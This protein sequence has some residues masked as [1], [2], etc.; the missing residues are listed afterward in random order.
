MVGLEGRVDAILF[1]A[2]I[3]ENAS[4]IRELCM[5]N[6]SS[7]GIELDGDK[8]NAPNRDVREISKDT[9]KIKVLVVPTNEELEI[10]LQAKDVIET[11]K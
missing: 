10:A 9:S 5:Q 4:E 6:L 8:N 1:T 3:G 2:G 11:N 7:L